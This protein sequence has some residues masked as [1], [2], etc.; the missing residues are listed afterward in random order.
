MPKPASGFS[1]RRYQGSRGVTLVADVG[2]DPASPPILLLHGG[3]QTRHSWSGAMRNLVARGYFV[4]NLDARGHG[5]SEWASDGDYTLSTLA[6][7][8]ACVTST[9]SARP[10]LVGA[11]MGG[12]ASLL[13]VGTSP[14]PTAAALVLVDIVPLIEASGASRI[15]AFMTDHLDG[16]ATLQDAAL[17][18]A[19]Y[20]PE[21][22]RP[23]SEV[24]LQKNLRQRADGRFYWHWDPRVIVGR[25]GFG[26]LTLDLLPQAA[27]AVRIPTL[28]V[29]GLK[30]DVV[31]DAG[32]ADLKS[33]IPQLEVIDVAEAGHMVTGDRNDLFNLAVS[34]FLEVRFP[35]EN[36]P[37]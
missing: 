28:L 17:A 14:A 23:M 7:D 36:G 13:W 25:D 30:S 18:I 1:I 10:A 24:G 22:S 32:V 27:K 3:G 19:A 31:S 21:R 20:S 12:A 34:R 35:V 29:R 33:R 9:L 4:V 5:D 11:S 16:F 2:G 15:R 6:Q 26:S 8:I 37:K